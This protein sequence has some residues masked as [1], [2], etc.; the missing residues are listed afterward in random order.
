M[1]NIGRSDRELIG[2][3]AFAPELLIMPPRVLD[4]EKGE[5][6]LVDSTDA[7]S[8]RGNTSP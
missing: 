3:N 6:I 2:V 4:G 8:G 1:Q 7:N 5:I